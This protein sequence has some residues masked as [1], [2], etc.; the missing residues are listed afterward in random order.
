MNIKHWALQAEFS[1]VL[2]ASRSFKG[3]AALFKDGCNVTAQSY[4]VCSGAVQG[5]RRSLAL[6]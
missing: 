4:G 2:H 5:S 1:W 3:Q 6:S